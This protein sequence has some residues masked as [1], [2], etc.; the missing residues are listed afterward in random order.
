MCLR[1]LKRVQRVAMRMIAGLVKST[2]LAALWWLLGVLRIEPYAQNLAIKTL[3]R[4]NQKGSF[5]GFIQ[6]G[7]T[8]KG[9][10]HWTLQKVV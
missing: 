7:V 4:L 9:D 6:K 1:M 2:P 5:A 10:A 3:Y 8:E